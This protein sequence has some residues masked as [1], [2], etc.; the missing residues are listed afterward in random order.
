MTR[1]RPPRFPVVP[2]TDPAIVLVTVLASIVST[3]LATVVETVLATFVVSVQATRLAHD[4]SAGVL[5]LWLTVRH[6]SSA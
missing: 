1:S 3:V 5:S 2:V 6:G 4:L